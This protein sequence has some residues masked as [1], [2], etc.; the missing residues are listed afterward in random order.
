MCELLGISSSVPI[1]ASRYL[2]LFYSHSVRHPHGWG[3]MYESGGER[4][5]IHEP[6]CAAD[7][8]ILGGVI[9]GLEPQ[10]T[11]L[12][13]IRLATV[14]SVC[15]ENCHPFT[16]F[17]MTGREWTLI[18][19]GTIY[20]G[21]MHYQYYKKQHGDTDSERLFLGLLDTVN[22]RIKLGSMSEHDRFETVS[23]FIIQNA[24][25]NKLNLMIWDGELLYV[26]KNLKNTL[27]YHRMEQG[28][29]FSTQPLNDSTW[30]PFPIAQ[31]IAF[32][33]GQLVYRGERHKGI[34][35]PTLEYI[36]AMDA[37]HI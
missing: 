18:H 23:Q 33:D 34:Y 1:D 26:H 9:S 29:L 5:I 27:S 20:S 22:E 28:Y 7:S 13:H 36:T 14:G 25:R 30:I 4:T 11:L 12:G 2:K 32:R 6:V 31:V 16:G 19:N 24:P 21:K 17:D 10:K 15:E 37:M 8:E 3:I 35:V